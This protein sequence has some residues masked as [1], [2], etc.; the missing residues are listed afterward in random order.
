MGEK[1]GRGGV[2]VVKEE[3]KR[4]MR[5]WNE[6]ERSRGVEKMGGGGERR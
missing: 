1:E 6:D 4:K 5:R 3:G 2:E